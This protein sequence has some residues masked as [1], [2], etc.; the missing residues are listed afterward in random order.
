[1]KPLFFFSAGVSL[2]VLA[3]SGMAASLPL[4]QIQF[5]TQA[6]GWVHTTSAEVTVAVNATLQPKQKLLK[7]RASLLA[8]LEKGYSQAQWHVSQVVQS[9]SQSGLTQLALLIKTRLPQSQAAGLS[10]QLS[11][12]SGHG[13]SYKVQSLSYTPSV[14]ELTQAQGKLRDQV[15]QQVK[16]EIARLNKTFGQ[17]FAVSALKMS[18]NQPN[19]SSYRAMP[20]AN[21]VVQSSGTTNKATTAASSGHLLVKADVTVS[22][23]LT[24]IGQS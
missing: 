3:A 22:A 16:A 7:V 10:Q 5:Q 14:G 17:H 8:K 11:K 18:F 19:V 9:K 24:T 12:F 2:A 20:V 15:Y 21:F 23:N 13:V 6:E 4:S 1:V